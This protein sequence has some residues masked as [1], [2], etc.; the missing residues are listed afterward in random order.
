[1]SRVWAV[2][3][4]LDPQPV[5]HAGVGSLLPRLGV[6]FTTATRSASVALRLIA[7]QHPDLFVVDPVLPPSEPIGGLECIT[8]AR[9]VDPRL[10]VVALS[11]IDD[12]RWRQEVLAA[13]AVAFVAKSAPVE[14]LESAIKDALEWAACGDEPLG[15]LLTHR[16]REILTLVAEGRTNGET[17][18]L[19]WLSP[20]TVKFHLANV[21]RKLHVS[22]R[23][24]AAR[25]ARRHGLTEPQAD[26]GQPP[27]WPAP[28]SRWRPGSPSARTDAATSRLD[29]ASG[30]ARRPAARH[31]PS[32]AAERR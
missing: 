1:V 25:W 18:R 21:Y 10:A 6:S 3:V 20:E 32:R 22:N 17:A 14:S 30:R 28:F 27:L 5:V 16:E 2:C 9:D 15:S 12:T 4:Q 8:R 11:A 29:R 23:S 13:G 31:H 19:L 24:E 7:T 26:P